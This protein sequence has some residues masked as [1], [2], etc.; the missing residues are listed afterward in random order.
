[1]FC[2]NT[3]IKWLYF[4]ILIILFGSAFLL[5]EISLKSFS[6]VGVAFIRV[7]IAAILLL[8]LTSYDKYNFS[9]IKRNFL[10]LFTLGL[11]GT[12]PFY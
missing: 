10:L 1:M 3:M 2:N 6:P 11:T 7:S 8:I 9:V 5:I 4:L 12:S